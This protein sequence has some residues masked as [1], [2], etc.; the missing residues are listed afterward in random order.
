MAVTAA[1]VWL[2]AASYFLTALQ[3][4]KGYAGVPQGCCVQMGAGT[5][6]TMPDPQLGVPGAAGAFS[7]LSVFLGR[8][9]GAAGQKP[10]G[11]S[12]V[13]QESGYMGPLILPEER[14]GTCS[15]HVLN[16]RKGKVEFLGISS[17]MVLRNVLL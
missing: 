8:V 17:I 6:G 1:R 4:P 10:A 9:W 2:G 15:P 11:K 7:L 5:W 14:T 12:M 16:G 3:P 13:A